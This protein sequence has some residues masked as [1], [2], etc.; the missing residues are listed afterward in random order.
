MTVDINSGVIATAVSVIG[1]VCAA[2]L[3]FATKVLGRMDL[4]EKRLKGLEEHQSSFESKLDRW[5]ERLGKAQRHI[6]IIKALG[7][8]KF[9]DGNGD[10]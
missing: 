6:S 4:L 5:G 2:T 1:T 8:F 10:E 7:D 9:E 3:W